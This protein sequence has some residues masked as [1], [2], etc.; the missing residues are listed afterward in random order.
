MEPLFD[1]L[2]RQMPRCKRHVPWVLWSVGI[3]FLWFFI[4]AYCTLSTDD[5]NAK[6][7]PFL[8]ATSRFMDFPLGY[9]PIIESSFLGGIAN[10]MLWGFF[11][12]WLFRLILRR[13]QRRQ[14][15]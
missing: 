7:H 1:K 15:L 6:A 5:G 11:L 10:C 8:D 9:I 12:V 2:A 13:F 14:S 4:Y 3:S